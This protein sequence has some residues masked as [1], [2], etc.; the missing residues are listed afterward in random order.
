[1]KKSAMIVGA[2][3]FA[4]ASWSGVA[5]AQNGTDY[6]GNEENPSAPQPPGDNGAEVEAELPA[7]SSTDS[8]APSAATAEVATQTL[9]VTGS[10]TGTLA[11]AGAVLVAG[12]GALV[13]RSRS[14]VDATV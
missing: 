3:A 2:A 10:N 13:W 12:G 4:V 9:P 5:G 14:T 7:P 11:L 6:T 1:M 8:A